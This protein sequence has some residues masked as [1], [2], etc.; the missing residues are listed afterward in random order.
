MSAVGRYCCK[1]LKMSGDEFF[2]RRPNKPRL[3]I[4]VVSG[5][6]SEVACEFSPGRLPFSQV[7]DRIFRTRRIDRIHPR[8]SAA[9]VNAQNELAFRK[10]RV[11]DEAARLPIALGKWV[12]LRRR[13][14][15]TS[16]GRLARATATAREN[17]PPMLAPTR[18]L[19]LHL[20]R[21]PSGTN[22]TCR[23]ASLMSG[24][25]GEADL[26]RMC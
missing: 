8:A 9:L 26:I 24:D 7:N 14:E 20:L 19:L 4:D 22:A 6:V 3:L 16:H 15:P 18:F 17:E 21:S 23:R 10:R 12:G 25:G 5:S 11:R 1:S 2:A 13:R